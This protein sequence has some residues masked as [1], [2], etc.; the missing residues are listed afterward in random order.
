MRAVLADLWRRWRTVMLLPGVVACLTTA[1]VPL[2]GGAAALF[3][4]LGSLLLS[5][6][7]ARGAGRAIIT[8]PVGKNDLARAWWAFGVAVPGGICLAGAALG[9]GVRLAVVS[10]TTPAAAAVGWLTQAVFTACWA[11]LFFLA[12]TLLPVTRES[13][14]AAQL[15]QGIGGALWGL[16]VGASVFI[17]QGLGSL[18]AKAPAIHPV[19]L[20]LAALAPV[21]L[22]ASWF[23]AGHLVEKRIGAVRTAAVPETVPM[24]GVGLP[25]LSRHF[26][27]AALWLARES[28]VQTTVVWGL[29]LMMMLTSRLALTQLYGGRAGGGA[30]SVPA[31]AAFLIMLPVVR[32]LSASLRQ[33]RTLP[34]SAPALAAGLVALPGLLLAVNA[35]LLQMVASGGRTP[36]AAVLA[37]GC[38]IGAVG[39]LGAAL[40]LRVNFLVTLVSISLGSGALMAA[41][42]AFR[43][44]TGPSFAVLGGTLL[45]AFALFLTA[46]ALA[47]HWLRTSSTPYRPLR[48]HFPGAAATA[49]A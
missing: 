25:G 7:L 4:L 46:F 32:V 16:N 33:L 22:A 9:W 36:A 49:R 8:Q 34:L 23:A 6:D 12:L 28:A 38:L 20:A 1:F 40:A 3:P 10:G 21:L 41:G 35:A 45:A 44:P 27:G 48:L 42:V 13:G 43:S 18:L 11:G 29:G 14:F 15:K 17:L 39:A 2:A 30:E 31:F 26:T 5:W 24:A 19:A 47:T 37:Q